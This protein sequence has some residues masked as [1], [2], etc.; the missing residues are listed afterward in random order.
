MNALFSAIKGA[1]TPP[2]YPWGLTGR[3]R[4][5]LVLV[6]HPGPE[7]KICWHFEYILA[8]MLKVYLDVF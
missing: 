5:T 8:S 4:L 3:P 1:H 2:P 7:K 6:G